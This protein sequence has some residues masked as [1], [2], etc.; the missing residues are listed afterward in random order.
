MLI[1]K[2]SMQHLGLSVI[3][4]SEDPRGRKL[5]TY[6]TRWQMMVIGAELYFL[7]MKGFT[8]STTTCFWERNVKLMWWLLINVDK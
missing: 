1:S 2:L 6:K 8:D 4:L 7:E 5:L 3:Y